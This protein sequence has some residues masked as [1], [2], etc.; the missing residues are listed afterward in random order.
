MGDED[1]PGPD[2]VFGGDPL[3]ERGVPFGRRVLERA[4][5]VTQEVTDGFDGLFHREVPGRGEA[6]G[7]R[8]DPGP[9]DQGQELPDG[10]RADPAHGR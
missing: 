3:P 5:V 10:R 4:P 6:A 1:L 2:A 8:D 9:V 7:Q